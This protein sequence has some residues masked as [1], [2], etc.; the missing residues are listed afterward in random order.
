MKYTSY[1][2]I[3]Q[4]PFCNWSADI[5]W[6]YL[7]ECLDGWKND[8]GLELSPDFQRGYVWT[9]KQQRDYV[10]YILRGG[11]SGKDIFWNSPE[12]GGEIKKKESDLDSTLLLVDGQQRIGA[13]LKFLRNEL[14]AFGTYY[15]DYEGKLRMLCPRFKF[16]VNSLQ[17]KKDV[18][19]WYLMLN[20]GGTVHTEEDLQSA[21]K[22]L[23]SLKK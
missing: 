13:V 23:D 17:Y 6:R 18:V 20:T 8:Y 5:D 2:E 3:P 12:F 21:Y 1:Q 4:F 9:E 16:N 19:N 14:K 22:I 10:E 15:K 7:E 11:F